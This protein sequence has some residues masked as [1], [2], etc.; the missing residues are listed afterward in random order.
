MSTSHY[1]SRP[2]RGL[3]GPPNTRKN[4]AWKRISILM[5]LALDAVVL[6]NSKDVVEAAIL[7]I[8]VLVNIWAL[9]Q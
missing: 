3:Q 8:L 7:V 4:T 2:F 6:L 5:L 1:S 9:N